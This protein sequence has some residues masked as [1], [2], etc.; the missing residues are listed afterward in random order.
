MDGQ[1]GKD[2]KDSQDG[3][4]AVVFS[5]VVFSPAGEIWKI[6]KHHTDPNLQPYRRQLY[7]VL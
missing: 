6:K 2:G 7:D 4:Q 5:R 1:D 3:R